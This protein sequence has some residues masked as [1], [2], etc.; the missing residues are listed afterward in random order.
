MARRWLSFPSAD[1]SL[2]RII[3]RDAQRGVYDFPSSRP[4]S[5][6]HI[7]PKQPNGVGRGG[8]ESSQEGSAGFAPLLQ[9]ILYDHFM[10]EM[11]ECEHE[12]ACH[13]QV[14]R[15]QER[16]GVVS[17]CSGPQSQLV[18]LAPHGRLSSLFRT[19]F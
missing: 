12:E 4:L 3:P 10:E 1:G 8:A 15:G 17:W 13:D 18:E 5:F 6:L 19:S 16:D 9:H 11:E 7:V 2:S 14:G